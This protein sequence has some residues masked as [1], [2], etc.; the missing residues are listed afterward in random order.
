ME[1]WINLITNCEHASA[2]CKRVARGSDKSRGSNQSRAGF[3]KSRVGGVPLHRKSFHMT[4]Y[5][6]KPKGRCMIHCPRM[7]L[8]GRLS[9]AALRPFG[10]TLNACDFGSYDPCVRV[11]GGNRKLTHP[12]LAG[13]AINSGNSAL[14]WGTLE[15]LAKPS[16]TTL[17]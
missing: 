7:G 16:R 14:Y 1:S 2:L 6:P 15:A 4:I 5:A 10:P 8:R 12:L 17:N 11:Y 13:L 3:N 9:D